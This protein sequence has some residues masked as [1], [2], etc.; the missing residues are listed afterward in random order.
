MTCTYDSHRAEVA[1]R[2]APLLAHVRANAAESLHIAD[3]ELATRVTAR[4]ITAHLP[5]PAFTNSQMDGY[6]VRAVDLAHASA[7]HPV[8][9]PLGYA[10]AAGDP[11]LWHA[12]GSA[13]PVMTGAPIPRGADTVVPV[14]LTVGGQFPKLMRAPREN[15]SI[16]SFVE[17]AT[18]PISMVALQAAIDAP[19]ELTQS[20]SQPVDTATYQAL[21]SGSATFHAPSP[22]GRFVRKA[23]EDLAAGAVVA[24]AGAALTPTMIG[25]LAA[26][27]ITQVPVRRRL[28]VLVCST[29]DELAHP[30][31]SHNA[32]HIPDANGPMLA[33]LLRRYGAEVDLT[34]VPDSPRQLAD[35]LRVHAGLADLI[36]TMGGISAGAFEVVRDALEPLG[37]EFHPVAMQPGGPQGFASITIEGVPD[38]P[39]LCFPGNPVSSFLSAELFLAPVL[40]EFAGLR[41]PAP[42]TRTLAHDVESPATKHQVRRGLITPEGTVRILPPGSHFV[43]DLASADVLVHIPVGVSEIA[44]GTPVE[45]WSFDV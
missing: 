44:A 38:T 12:P 36:V 33:A 27:G 22:E 31:E 14:E 37:G 6:A 43:H 10:A 30:G 26:S 17:A 29:G 24:A 32:A 25:A 41:P 39:V 7:D 1:A 35:R 19:A 4:E 21:P 23:G 40:R 11:Q 9:L 15:A 8:T 16:E 45:T 34:I 3:P 5:I 2:L 28:R 13:T 20:T 18:G 42:R